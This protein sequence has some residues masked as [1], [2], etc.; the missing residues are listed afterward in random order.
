MNYKVR[1]E[2]IEVTD[3]IDNYI[4]EKL[5]KLSKFF[6]DPENLDVKVVLRVRGREQKVEVTINTA[7]YDLRAEESSADLYAAVDLVVD[8]LERQIRKFKTKLIDKVRQETIEE[9]EDYFDMDDQE[10]VKRKKVFLK[11]MDEEEA[12]TQMELLGHS[13]FVF[14]NTDSDNICV[15]YKRIDGDFGIIETN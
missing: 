10:I 9:V 6:K 12:M 14:K 13:F 3:A 5:G 11:P 1:G 15:L 8:K 2:N 7:K 4:K